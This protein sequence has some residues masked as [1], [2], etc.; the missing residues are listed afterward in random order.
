MSVTPGVD[1]SESYYNS[2]KSLESLALKQPQH[3][4]ANI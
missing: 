4:I 1:N 3:C 2:T